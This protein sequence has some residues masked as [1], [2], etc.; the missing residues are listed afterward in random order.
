MKK[1][2]HGL[3]IWHSV[4]LLLVPL[5]PVAT[6]ATLVVSIDFSTDTLA[7]SSQG[8][9]LIPIWAL[10]M[11][12]VF[13]GSIVLGILNIIQGCK[14]YLE[15][16]EQFCIDSMLIEKYGMIPFF[17]LNIIS[18]ILNHAIMLVAGHGITLLLVPITVPVSVA[19]TYLYLIP[20]SLWGLHTIR[21]LKNKGTFSDNVATIL[22]IMQFVFVT[23]VVS[24]VIISLKYTKRARIISWVVL[25]L[26]V[27]LI[28]SATVGV[29]YAGLKLSAAG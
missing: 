25:G 6:V 27:L 26:L 7:L 22:C 17:G 10:A 28:V 18:A 21:L 29:I 3:Q 23:D 4:I 19:V 9:F 5:M 15:C 8:R 12:G 20:G 14:K 16:D 13:G 2:G 1:Q 11:L 24:A